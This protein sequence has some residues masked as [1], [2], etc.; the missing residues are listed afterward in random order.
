M[1]VQPKITRLT[2][3]RDDTDTLKNLKGI[4]SLSYKELSIKF[5]LDPNDRDFEKRFNTLGGIVKS[6][7]RQIDNRRNKIDKL[8]DEIKER[9]NRLVKQLNTWKTI[10]SYIKPRVVLKKPTKSYPYWKGRVWFNIGG[11]TLYRKDKN[12]D[13]QKVNTKGRNIE[14]HL[15]SDKYRKDNNLTDDD[16]REMGVRK[17]RQHILKEDFYNYIPK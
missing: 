16:L 4:T 14:L 5:G 17:F 13:T 15:C 7:N 2:D 9:Q 1:K 10:L 3:R 11:N 6:L 8:E 12:K